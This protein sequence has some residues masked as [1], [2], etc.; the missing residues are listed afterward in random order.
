MRKSPPNFA[1]L[2][3]VG[4]PVAIG[5]FGP[6]QLDRTTASDDLRSFARCVCL[7]NSWLLQV[8][9]HFGGM[10]R[11][12]L[13]SLLA[14]DVT[15]AHILAAPLSLAA[16]RLPQ[17]GSGTRTANRFAPRNIAYTS[18]DAGPLAF[19]SPQHRFTRGLP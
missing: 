17:A 12:A 3:R 13:A 9:W 6:G 14:L 4:K 1:A 7:S 10:H 15:L 18:F 2:R 19:R 8:T 16:A 11:R 5:W